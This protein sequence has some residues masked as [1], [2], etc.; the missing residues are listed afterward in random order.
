MSEADGGVLVS[1]CWIVACKPCV[2]A[3]HDGQVWFDKD[4]AERICGNLI[5]NTGKPYKVISCMI[6]INEPSA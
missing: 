4:R 2:K 1:E 5:A 6:V 3:S